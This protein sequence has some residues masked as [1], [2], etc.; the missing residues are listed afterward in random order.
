METL[1]QDKETIVHEGFNIDFIFNSDKPT[2]GDL[3][4]IVGFENPNFPPNSDEF[5]KMNKLDFSQID[6]YFG[7]KN[8][9]KKGDDIKLWLI[10]II[11]NKEVY[12]NEGPFDAIR[13][14][15]RILRNETKT[16]EI[17]RLVFDTF[18]ESLNV[19]I[20]R[21]GKEINNY[22]EIEKEIDELINYCKIQLKVEPGSHEAL[23]LDW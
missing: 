15:Y 21:N 10:P 11:D 1:R 20:I 13:L 5:L 12:H 23:L 18:K 3:F 8:K 17:F 22:S 4:L 7:I 9:S 16:K 14:N 19:T 6:D 2:F